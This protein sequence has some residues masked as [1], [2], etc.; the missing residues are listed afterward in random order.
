MWRGSL[1][2]LS[3]ATAA[4]CFYIPGM[5]LRDYV[6][7]DAVSVKVNSLFSHQGVIPYDFYSLKFCSP[8]KKEIRE[9]AKKEKL[10]ELIW[11]DK[12]EPSLYRAEMMQTVK[13]RLVEC[14]DPA[15]R[16]VSP[17]DLKRFENRINE[18]YRGAFVL[19]NLPVVSNG[20]WVLGGQCPSGKQTYDAALRGFPLGV[21]QACLGKHT[22]INNH[23]AFQIQV[24]EHV[25]GRFII[26][27]FYVTAHSIDHKAAENCGES[28]R[29]DDN[30]EP[31]TTDP[32]KTR[33]IF[34]SYSVSWQPS[35]VV[36]GHRWDAYL[37]TSFSNR[38]A[39]VHWLAIVNSLLI[40]LCLSGVV[41]MIFLRVLH[42]D[43]NRY[44]SVDEADEQQ[45]ETGWKLVHGDV[46]RPPEHPS[47]FAVLIGTGVQLLGMFVTSLIFALLGFLSP[48]NRGGL[49]TALI[50]LFVLMAFANGY[51]VAILLNLFG[52]K[53]WKTVV[54][55]GMGYPGFLFLCWGC[56]DLIL[57]ST[58]GANALPGSAVLFLMGLWFG[59][60][61][62][63]VVLGAAFGFRREP[64]VPPTKVSRNPR[65]IPPQRFYLQTP[66]LCLVPGI[67]PFGAAFI[68]MRFIMSSLWQGMV[69]YVF[70]FLGL[71][72][73]TVVV[74]T[75][76]VTIVLVYFLLVFEDHRWWWRSIMIP[77]GMGIHFFLFAIYY[78]QT[79]LKI[80]TAPG[81][82]IYM[83]FALAV[84]VTL[85]IAI[86][87]IGWFSAW[88]FVRVIYNRIKIE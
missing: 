84:S 23:V 87:T 21:P 81:T 69:Y 79:Q 1:A 34:W 51:T 22:Y 33:E 25:P 40:I 41:A 67:I 30:H 12:I 53:Q 29:I 76:E 38:N 5:P 35:D 2:L 85:F 72:F 54:L 43:F 3:L 27:G 60:G 52:N 17:T 18:G 48:A 82:L 37:S 28:F 77:G 4:Q 39:R 74:A 70:G 20:S 58:E 32:G 49:L 83:M 66:F 55:A 71:S 73:L 65:V 8:T 44:N 19:D 57:L 80:R 26:V 31:I 7:G 46:F 59:I 6:E 13:C 63:L 78:F 42:M 50:L 16:Q 88:I 68:E 11:G 75:A 36:W 10:G 14:L 24:N 15:N 64:I 47:T 86:G 62:P 56:D 45:E 61:V 9:K